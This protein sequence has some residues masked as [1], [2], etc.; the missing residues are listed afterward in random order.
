MIYGRDLFGFYC[1]MIIAMNYQAAF[2]KLTAC[3]C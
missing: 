2:R 3:N 1:Q